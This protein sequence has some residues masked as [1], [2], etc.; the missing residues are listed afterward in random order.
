MIRKRVA[1]SVVSWYG[2]H[3][4]SPTM[5]SFAVNPISPSAIWFIATAHTVRPT[6]REFDQWKLRS[7]Q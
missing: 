6:T 2:I 1:T 4:G 5:S 7:I 3:S